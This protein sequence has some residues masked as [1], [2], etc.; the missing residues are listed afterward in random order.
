MGFEFKYLGAVEYQNAL[1]IQSDLC[2]QIKN[3]NSPGIILGLEHPK[4]LT[5]GYRAQQESEVL[6]TN[7]MPVVKV[8][9]G[10]LATIHSEGQL[11][12][13]PILNLKHFKIGVREYVELLLKTTQEMLTEFGAEI[14]AYTEE[15]V[16]LYTKKGKIAFCGIQIKEGVSLH[17]LSINISNDLDLFNNIIACGIQNQK[18]DKLINYSTQINLESLFSNW[19]S[20][21]NYN[22]KARL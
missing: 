6:P 21:F 14:E 5:L 13:Y 20:H 12:I 15:A 16:G 8:N 4:V 11:I 10:G 17:G 9:R 2:A 3:E 7:H 19:L 22:M 18:L 1:I